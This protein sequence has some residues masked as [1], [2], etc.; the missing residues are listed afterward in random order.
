MSSAG[1]TRV[2][3]GNWM[4]TV[5]AGGQT[6]S[7]WNGVNTGVNTVLFN[8]NTVGAAGPYTFCWAKKII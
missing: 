2:I 4:I 7:I 8:H 6:I 3:T 1:T 5:P